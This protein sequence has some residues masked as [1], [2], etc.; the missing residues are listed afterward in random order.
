M[1][2]EL[3]SVGDLEVV[4]K[5]SLGYILQNGCI[6]SDTFAEMYLEGLTSTSG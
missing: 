3:G 4:K 1:E 2:T 6:I 5:T